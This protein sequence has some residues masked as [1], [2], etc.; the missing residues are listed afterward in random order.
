MIT[1]L[2]GHAGITTGNPALDIGNGND[3]SVA[4]YGNVG[5]NDP[6]SSLTE[7]TAMGGGFA[8]TT[9]ANSGP[10]AFPGTWYSTIV[11]LIPNTTGGDQ[12][13][14][15]QLRAWYNDGGTTTS[16][17]NAL[18]E[19]YPAGTSAL[20]NLTA[21]GGVISD[22]PALTAPFLPSGLGNFAV[23]IP[24]P[25]AN[26]IALCVTGRFGAGSNVN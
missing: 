18:A 19:G 7:C 26:T 15:L 3:W 5:L 11:A 14:T 13:A 16:F 8:T 10:D 9:F 21:T 2:G 23:A 20:A 22:G 12:T 4:L 1:E 24:V 25:E 17:G 6:A